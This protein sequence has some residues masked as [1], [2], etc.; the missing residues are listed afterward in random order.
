[1]RGATLGGDARVYLNGWMDTLGA[2]VSLCG[3]SGLRGTGT[4]D[5][6]Y[7]IGLDAATGACR[8]L[9]ERTGS[10]L[11]QSPFTTA[12]R[13]RVGA[14]LFAGARLLELSGTSERQR[15]DLGEQGMF[16]VGDVHLRPGATDD[17]L[18]HW[19]RAS[20]AQPTLGGTP[21]GTAS[22]D[23]LVLV[24]G[25]PPSVATS[26][27]L[28]RE[29]VVGWL[30]ASRVFVVAPSSGGEGF[31]CENAGEH[32]STGALRIEIREAG[33][34]S[35]CSDAFGVAL[36][37]SGARERAAVASGANVWT[38]LLMADRFELVGLDTATGAVDTR[39]ISAAPR[40]DES[41]TITHLA[42]ASVGDAVIGVTLAEGADG[43]RVYRGLFAR[44][45]LQAGAI[46]ER[47]RRTLANGVVGVSTSPDGTIAYATAYVRDTAPLC[48]GGSFVS[49]G[50]G[51]LVHAIDLEP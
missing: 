46:V 47:S 16:D 49:D 42:P 39:T 10:P 17:L 4:G 32:P 38:L 7:T 33:S 31:P 11:P 25:P 18:V 12:H 28:P 20:A 21:V 1:L 2:D 23:P 22:S 35:R 51:L 5:S 9:L 24:T 36:D 19:W 41:D 30:D 48:A 3:V 37:P 13:G 50:G 6:S 29:A 26:T 8:S 14:W 34:L 15:L 45:G 44:H 27:A 40:S 43:A